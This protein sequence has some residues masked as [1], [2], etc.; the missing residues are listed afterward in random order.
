MKAVRRAK[1]A[2][3][4][5]VATAGTTGATDTVATATVIAATAT[6]TP[7]TGRVKTAGHVKASSPRTMLGTHHKSNCK[8]RH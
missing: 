8:P 2:E 6:G 3:T 5:R 4:V 1:T 7:A